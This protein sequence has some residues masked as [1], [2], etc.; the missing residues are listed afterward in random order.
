MIYG[1]WIYFS[2]AFMYS[3]VNPLIKRLLE[4]QKGLCLETFN[5]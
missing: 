2:Y 3:E 1:K 4:K 5:F